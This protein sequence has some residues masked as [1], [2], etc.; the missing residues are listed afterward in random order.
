MSKGREREN[1]IMINVK[2]S[3]KKWLTNYI[4]EVCN[5]HMRRIQVKQVNLGIHFAGLVVT[6]SFVDVLE[7]L[8][9]LP[10][11]SKNGIT[12]RCHATLPIQMRIC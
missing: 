6:V 4:S 3:D 7:L 10:P 8:I 9:L 5:G 2:L 11:L 12:S 1:D